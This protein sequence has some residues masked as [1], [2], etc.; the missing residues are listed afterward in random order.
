MN[1]RGWCP[2]LFTPMPS[3]DG[4][5]VRLRPRRAM[6][7][8]ADARTI[9]GAAA[10]H[11]NGILELTQRGNLQIR[12]LTPTSAGLFAAAMVA[13][14]LGDSGPNLLVSPLAGADPGVDPHS[15][16]IADALDAAAPELPD[17]FLFLVDGGG[18]VGL[19]GIRADIAARAE[20]GKWRLWIDGETSGAD[21]KATSVPDAMLR[22]ARGFA[23]SGA[24]RMR[25]R[26]EHCGASR[27]FAQAGLVAELPP[28]PVLPPDILGFRAYRDHQ[29]SFGLGVP[30]GALTAETLDQLATLAERF[31]DAIL[32]LTPFRTVL[33]AGVAAAQAAALGAA[34]SGWITDPE[35]PRRCITA[36]I[37]HPR[38]AAATVDTHAAAALLAASA[39]AR[40]VHI[41]GCAKGCAHPGPAPFTLVGRDGAY[42]IVRNGRAHDAPDATGLTLGQAA[43]I[44]TGAAAP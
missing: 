14:R 31:G 15:I 19:R 26:V 9:A 22:L 16:A 2:S 6:L 30:F 13:A 34:A 18:T 35:D 41:S 4:W 5:L 25:D 36:C 12:G 20:D 28:I 8:A 39:P 11:G 43:A 3:G 42:D 32:R 17:K 27:I 23:A 1:S 29:G 21:C 38:C 37:G 10:L 40:F 44:L 24:R 7:S 33:I